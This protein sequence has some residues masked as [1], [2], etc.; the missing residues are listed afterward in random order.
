MDNLL[1]TC[2][3][4]VEN[5]SISFNVKQLAAAVPGLRS[6]SSNRLNTL[7]VSRAWWLPWFDLKHP[8]RLGSQRSV[9]GGDGPAGGL[10][11]AGGGVPL[12][13]LAW[14]LPLFCFPSLR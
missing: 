14:S 8:L 2:E 3:M 9:V 13:H 1:G 4:R 5:I 11:V 12:K 6:T 7:W 10:R